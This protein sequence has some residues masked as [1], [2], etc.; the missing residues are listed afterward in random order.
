[1]AKL[2][3]RLLSVRLSTSCVSNVLA[4]K[5]QKP[6]MFLTSYFLRKLAC[7]CFARSSCA[8][9]CP[10]V[11]YYKA[12]WFLVVRNVDN[13]IRRINHC[14]GHS[15]VCFVKT[16]PNY[17]AYELLGPTLYICQSLC[18]YEHAWRIL[19]R[20]QVFLKRIEL[21]CTLRFS[22]KKAYLENAVLLVKVPRRTISR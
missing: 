6:D 19:L 20:N 12:A 17:P 21:S 10:G 16:Y 5:P 1:M 7:S 14:P 15:V 8:T 13:A 18:L 4:G 3:L 2:F 22:S 11:H 9:S